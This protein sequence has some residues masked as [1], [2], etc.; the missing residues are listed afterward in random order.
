MDGT[1]TPDM[2][3]EHILS[4][5]RK[6]AQANGGV[7]LGWR[8]FEEQTGIKYYDWYGKHWTRWS[9]AVQEAGLIPN[10]MSEPYSREVLLEK[11]V[12]LTR[13]LGRV[14]TQGDLLMATRRDPSF[15]SEKAFRKLGTKAERAALVV[16]YCASRPA[17]DAVGRLWGEVKQS[18][19]AV[20]FQVARNNSA[21]VGYV[22]L[23]KFGRHFKIGRTNA[24]GR[25]ERE[26]AIQLPERSKTV[27]VISTDDPEGIEAYWHQRFAGKRGNG[28][29]F[30]LDRNDIAAFKRRRFM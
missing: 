25:R 13:E 26:L 29:W 24:V 19:H 18:E 10:R 2:T 14:P 23:T 8:R 16:T 27:H 30:A 11:L 7:A 4:E 6:T 21:P 3:K 1:P 17:N 28:E 9:D 12:T 5:L 20:A 22:Y 15:P